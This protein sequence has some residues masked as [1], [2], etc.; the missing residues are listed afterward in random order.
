MYY[1]RSVGVGD[2]FEL[3]HTHSVTKRLVRETFL[4]ADADTIA[5]EVLW[6]DTFGANLPTGPERIGEVTTTFETTDDGYRVLHHSRPIGSVPLLV[7]GP[8]VD[9]TLTFADGE[10]VR[11]LEVAPARSAVELAVRDPG[12]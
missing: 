7:G 12:T 4:V 11:L 10:Q 8:E 1:E 3:A 5:M 6:F 2:E 9:H